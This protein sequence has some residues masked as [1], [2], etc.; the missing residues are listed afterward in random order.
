M[1]KKHETCVYEDLPDERVAAFIALS[2]K[3]HSKLMYEARPAKSGKPDHKDIW[4]YLKP[5]VD[6]E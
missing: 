6:P 1:E 3:Q 5:G 4:S 2:K